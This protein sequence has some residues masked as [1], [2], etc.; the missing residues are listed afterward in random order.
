M[1][2]DCPTWKK[3]LRDEKPSVLRVTKGSSL[4]DGGDIFLVTAK[5]PGKLD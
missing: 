4:F 5:S 3:D 1:K 2:K